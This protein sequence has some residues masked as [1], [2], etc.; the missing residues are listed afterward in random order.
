MSGREGGEPGFRSAGSAGQTPVTFLPAAAPHPPRRS[1]PTFFSNS[2][3]TELFLSP[4]GPGQ[5]T[6]DQSRQRCQI[7]CQ[8]DSFQ[9]RSCSRG[10]RSPGDGHGGCRVGGDPTTTLGVSHWGCWSDRQGGWWPF[11]LK[12]EE[13]GG[14]GRG[15]ARSGRRGGAALRAVSGCVV[16]AG[17]SLGASPCAPS[18]PR[19]APVHL[20]QNGDFRARCNSWRL[21][22]WRGLCGSPAAM[23]VCCGPA[24]AGA[25]KEPQ[26]RPFWDGFAI[27]SLHQ[28]APLAAAGRL[29]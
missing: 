26:P 3:N 25:A 18:R 17:S 12:A 4:V 6:F 13:G 14:G 19:Y 24:A 2:E 22:F 9:T 7:S 11:L 23:E 29:S 5:E 15:G 1:L 8:S 27:T 21:R 10:L 20:P 28:H 16:A